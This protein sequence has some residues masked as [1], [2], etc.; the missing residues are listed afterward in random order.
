[1]GRFIRL[2]AA[3]AVL[4]FADTA[5][6]ERREGLP[7]DTKERREDVPVDTKERREGVPGDTKERREGVP[8]DTAQRG[9][10]PVRALPPV[11]MTCPMHP[12]IVESRPGSCPLCKMTLV[13]VRLGSSWMCPIHSAVMRD[14]SGSCPLCRRQLVRVSVALTWTC[15]AQPGIDRMEPGTCADGTPMV[16]RRTLR[17][18]GNHNPQ[19]GGQFFMA[20]DHWHHLEGTYP[21][22]RVF[23]LYLYDDYAR[24]LSAADLRRVQARV[25]TRE[26][27]DAAAR[28][29]TEVSAFA[30]RPSRDGEYLE[31]RVDRA[32]PPAEM[33]AK[34]RLKPGAPEY[35]FDFT[36]QTLTKEPARPPAA[37]APTPARQTAVTNPPVPSV[38]APT[39]VAAGVPAEPAF[40]PVPIPDTMTGIVEQLKVRD[41]QIRDLIRQGNFTAVWVPAFHAKDLAVALEPHVGHLAPRAREAAEPAIQRLVRY[42][43]LLDAFGD[44][45]NR[46]QLEAAYAAF[47]TA[48]TDVASAFAG[49]Q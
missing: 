25:V 39:D 34:V 44:V 45:G 5:A 2:A 21:R 27:F 6:E 11:S 40:V 15:S 43:W 35:R 37:R 3:L 47:S 41:A 22:E 20:P 1:M 28:K 9:I 49:A 29:T 17:P 24:P 18:H 8:V 4:L 19:H 16:P 13:P 23:R 38:P 32:S 30:L 12:D 10:T 7:G 14:E 48:V 33:T 36:F 46:Q 26:T 42:A 31:A